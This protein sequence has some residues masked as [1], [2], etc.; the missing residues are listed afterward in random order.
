MQPKSDKPKILIA[1]RP[2]LYDLLFADEQ[3]E[4]LASLGELS[5][6]TQ[7]GDL[8]EAQL[9]AVI[10]GQDIVITSW[11]T[12]NFSPAV[13]AA[14][15][16]LKLIAHSAGSIKRMLPPPVFTTGRRVTHVAYSMSIPVA[17]T[18][19]ALILLCLRNY[20]KFDR[21]FK[22]GGWAAA[23]ALPAGGE[24]AGNRVGV[25][26][27]GYTGR[28][29][30]KRLLALDAE[31]WLC[32]PYVDEES[33]KAMGVHLAALEPLMRE[34]PIITLQAPA[35]A[36]T[37]RMI[38]REQLSW[39]RDGAIFIN[40]ARAHLIDEAA[41]LAELQTGRISAALD[42]FDQEPLPDDSPFRGLDNLIITPH[43][44]AVT[45]QAYKR[46]GEIT[47]DEVARYLS[48]GKLRYEVTRDMLDT[49]A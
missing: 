36:E 37:Y 10:G 19:L 8:T 41:L 31:V 43:I 13:L 26:G 23:R 33:A 35:T 18:T 1:L 20:H 30:I 28:A 46:Q 29:V 47:V 9:T 49:M 40:T 11:G 17:E 38:G 24:L 44:A 7:A 34:C 12:P 16:R 6:Q 45:H 5:R 27:A 15:D 2:A 42:V 48:G 25:I 32:D 14:A 22:D 3:K 21:A 39:L 4:R